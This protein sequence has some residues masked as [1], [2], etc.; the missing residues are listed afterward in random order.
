MPWEWRIELL[1]QFRAV[2]GSQ[3]FTHARMRKASALLAYLAYFREREHPRELLIELLWPE[4][5]LPSSRNNLSTTLTTLRHQLEPAG[6]APGSVLLTSRFSV[7]LNPV[8]VTTDA[9]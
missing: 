9:A 2:R 5:D 1:G 8:V 6:V 4:T 7:Q 3:I